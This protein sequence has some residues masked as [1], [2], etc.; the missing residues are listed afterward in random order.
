LEPGGGLKLIGS[1]LKFD[2]DDER[3][4]IFLVATGGEEKRM[5]M[6]VHN[7]PST[8]IFQLPYSMPEGRYKLEVRTIV[9]GTSEIRKGRL[10]DPV[11]IN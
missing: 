2:P 7:K 3:Q 10:Q 6:V 11:V 8:L 5:E 1:F 4:G 9:R